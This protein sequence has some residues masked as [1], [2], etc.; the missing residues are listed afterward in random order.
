MTKYYL[1][2]ELDNNN[3][4]FSSIQEI[5]DALEDLKENEDTNLTLE[6]LNIYDTKMV[7]LTIDANS[8]VEYAI[9]NAGI[10]DDF[11]IVEEDDLKNLQTFLNQWCKKINTNW[12]Q[13]SK[14]LSID[15]VYK[16]LE[17]KK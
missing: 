17:L 8:I 9:E 14:K 10:I 1:V 11:A 4:C 13:K 15:E 7:Q 16:R 3:I 5:V 12:Y 2:D 6:Q